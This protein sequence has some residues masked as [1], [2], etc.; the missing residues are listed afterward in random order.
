[1]IFDIKAT[2]PYQSSCVIPIFYANSGYYPQS[3]S[4]FIIT[5]SMIASLL[6][7]SN[8]CFVPCLCQ[9]N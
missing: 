9:Y 1:M 2:I 6:Y 3:T 7:S 5:I 4:A 8:Q